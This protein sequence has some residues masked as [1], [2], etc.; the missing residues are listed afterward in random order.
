MKMGSVSFRGLPLLAVF[1]L[2]VAARPAYAQT[3]D[4]SL[5][6]DDLRP[7]SGVI[8][9]HQSDQSAK[10]FTGVQRLEWLID[11][12]IGPGSLVTGAMSAGLGTG[13]NNP[14]ISGGGQSF[15][16]RYEMH[17]AGTSAGNAMEATFGAA[18]EEDPRYFRVPTEPIGMRL[19]NVIKMTFVA[20]RSD[21]N[22]APAYAR[23]IGIAGSSFLAD[24][25]EP[26]S[27][28]NLHD[29]LLRTLTGLLGRMGSN[30]FQEFWPNV[31]PH[32]FHHVP[33]MRP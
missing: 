30:A 10:D 6:A 22:L 5:M 19:R 14:R 13:S 4:S 8:L 24:S 1:A 21:G 9:V 25:W 27:E 17:I 7:E 16:R 31:K 2:L 18:W 12:T 3:Q 33:S 26:N 32:L 23:Y 29:A 15:V 28:A 11:S 20:Y